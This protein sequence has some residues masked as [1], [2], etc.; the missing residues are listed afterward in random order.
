[1]DADNFRTVLD[2][3]LSVANRGYVPDVDEDDFDTIDF[4]V[5]ET[6]DDEYTLNFS[7]TLEYDP[8]RRGLVYSWVYIHCTEYASSIEMTRGKIV[9]TGSMQNTSKGET[10]SFDTIG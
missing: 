7:I 4:G 10:Y 9:F 3:G 5:V 8:D 1:M 2:S 6:D